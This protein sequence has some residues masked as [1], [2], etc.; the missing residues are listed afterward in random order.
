MYDP[1]TGKKEL[2]DWQKGQ[3]TEGDFN[4]LN[5]NVEVPYG[6]LMK[7]IDFSNRWV[8][9]GSL[10][11]PPCTTGV[12]HHVVDRI[13]PIRKEHWDAYVAHQSTWLQTNIFN[14]KGEIDWTPKATLDTHG[15]F[16]IA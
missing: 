14:D 7:I 15:N 3:D 12:Y 8:Y 9:S 6:D 13:L 5:R 4:V 16:R 1:A 11:T 10:T 2:G